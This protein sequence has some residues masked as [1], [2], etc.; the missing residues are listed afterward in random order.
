MQDLSKCAEPQYIAQSLALDAGLGLS[1]PCCLI[2]MEQYW[3]AYD[4]ATAKGVAI[5][6]AKKIKQTR[7]VSIAEAYSDT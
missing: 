3:P 4:C 6:I 5:A 1:S 7:H 2:S